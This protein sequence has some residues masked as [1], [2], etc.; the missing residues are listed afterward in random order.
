[1]SKSSEGKSSGTNQPPRGPMGMGPGMGMLPVQKAKDFK[2][3]LRRLLKYLKPYRVKLS[4]VII[5]AILSTIFGIFGPKILGKATTKLAEG[6]F[7]MAKGTPGAH[8]DFTYIWQIVV[9]LVCL[10]IIS[11]VFGYVQQYLMAGVAQR[12]VYDMR[13]QI[14]A[15]VGRL[16]LKYFD[17]TSNGEILAVP[18]MTWTISVIHFSKAWHSLLRLSSRLSA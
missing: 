6:V 17:S 7:A 8:I 15:K 16:P 5:T 18:R 11:A 4:V 10:Y 9:E 13:E 14:S 1:M 12:V 2:G 3:T